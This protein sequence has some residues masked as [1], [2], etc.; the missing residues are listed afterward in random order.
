MGACMRADRDQLLE[1]RR[2]SVV[3]GTSAAGVLGLIGGQSKIPK[4]APV[5]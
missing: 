2:I 4:V 5:E 3:G 1:L